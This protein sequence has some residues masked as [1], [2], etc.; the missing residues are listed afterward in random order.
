[1]VEARSVGRR[2]SNR[3]QATRETQGLTRPLFSNPAK[4]LQNIQEEYP[5]GADGID[6]ERDFKKPR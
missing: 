4:N 3:A 2:S 6:Y 5:R 1:V